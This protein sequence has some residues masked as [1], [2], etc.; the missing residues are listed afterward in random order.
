MSGAPGG[1]PIAKRSARGKHDRIYCTEL[2]TPVGALHLAASERG[3]CYVALPHASGDGLTGHLARH[4]PGTSRERAFAPLR[5]AA[6][7]I[8]QYLDGKRRE[9]S[10]ELDPRGTPFQ[11]DVWRALLEIPY[12]ETR[13]YGEL[14]RVVGKPGGARAVGT[15][16]GSNPL[17]LIV[18]CH[19]VIQSGGGIG[20]YGGGVALKKRLLAMERSAV[21]SAAQGTLL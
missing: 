9:F 10:V 1:G 15:A 4:F 16:N 3:L 13:S 12:G 18:P 5:K 8:L 7:E 19:R 2:D 20:G 21:G 17:S 14:A 11:R 6:Q